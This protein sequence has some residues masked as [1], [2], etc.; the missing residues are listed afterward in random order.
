L[1]RRDEKAN[2]PLVRRDGGGEQK[3]PYMLREGYIFTRF[4][5]KNT[6]LGWEGIIMRQIK[7]I[8]VVALSF[9]VAA[10]SVHPLPSDVTGYKTA[11]IVR[12]IRCEA[13]GAIVQAAFEIL[14]RNGR[15]EEVQDETSLHATMS[16]KKSLDS[17]E[18]PKLDQLQNIGIV[19]NFSLE[20]VENAS[21]VLNADIIKPIKRGTETLSPSLGN[22][23]K[24]DNTR[25]F[26]VS[27]SFATLLKLQ[28]KH[29]DDFVSPGPN[30]EYPMV[31]RIGLDE[32]VQTFVRLAVSGDLT[33]PEDLSK[34][35]TITL[36]PAGP[37]TMVD[38]IIFTTTISAGL[39]PKIMLSPVGTAAQF[40]DATL[41]GTASRVDT[42][43]VMIG[44]ALGK[45]S[46]PLSPAAV[47][48]ALSPKT[49]ALFF[50]HQPKEPTN[51]GEALAAQ[52]VTQQ[53]LRSELHRATIAIVP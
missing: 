53:I 41:V 43:E 35:T 30:Y 15:H 48:A 10:C 38:T 22:T 19:Y 29:C 8:W 24:R 36:D 33:A 18:G 26:T 45:S 40:M 32:M 7:R 28:P 4:T 1:T 27:D 50:T 2:F 42:H 16:N 12:K 14:H 6:S 39:T 5:C 20:G 46:T 34:V 25:A 21:A 23:L 11:T 3:Y 37:P 49:T 9:G 31:G 17:W 44:M 51:S 47:A 52:A 13:K